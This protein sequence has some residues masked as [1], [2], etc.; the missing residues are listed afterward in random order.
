MKMGIG[1]WALG[2]SY[3]SLVP[4]VPLVPCF[5]KSV[6]MNCVHQEA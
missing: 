4:L 1:H 6:V 5:F 3:F 2:I